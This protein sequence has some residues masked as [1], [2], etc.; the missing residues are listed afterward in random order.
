VVQRRV[1]GFAV[2]ADASAELDEAR[3]PAAPGPAEPGIQQPF[4]FLALEGEDLPEL[5][6][7]Q[8]APEQLMVDLRDPG[9]WLAA[10]R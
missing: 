2:F 9:A 8:V 7:N 5:L 1:D 3:D 10:G 4:A 6:F